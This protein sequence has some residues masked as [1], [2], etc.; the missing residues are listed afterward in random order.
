MFKNLVIL[1]VV[2]MQGAIAGE[3][4]AQQREVPLV[5]EITEQEAFTRCAVSYRFLSDMY[6]AMDDVDAS[7]LLVKL[8]RGS[9]VAASI[10]AIESGLGSSEAMA[11]VNQQMEDMIK[12]YE[13]KI[14]SDR[15]NIDKL[16]TFWTGEVQ[17]CEGMVARQQELIDQWRATQNSKK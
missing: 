2:A 17:N 11:Q 1:L 16:V 12:G 13:K 3:G 5:V 14:F 10:L 9:A 8:A 15:N 4:N 6:K 7:A